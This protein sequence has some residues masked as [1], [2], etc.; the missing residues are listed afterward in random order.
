MMFFFS[1]SIRDSSDNSQQ[2]SELE[3]RDVWE[4]RDHHH[5]TMWPLEGHHSIK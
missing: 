3:D 2:G 5:E 4:Q 1:I